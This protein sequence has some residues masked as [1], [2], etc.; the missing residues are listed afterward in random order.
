MTLNSKFLRSYCYDRG[1]SNS[2]THEKGV[3]AQLVGR[4]SSR[5]S[6]SANAMRSACKRAIVWLALRGYL[7]PRFATWAL[8][9]GD[10]N[11]A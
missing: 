3:S 8:K 1:R 4:S 7:S 11:D 9:N 6:A 10:L 5:R 2:D